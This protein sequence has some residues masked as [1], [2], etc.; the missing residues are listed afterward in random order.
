MINV[1]TVQNRVKQKHKSHLMYTVI[2]M[3]YTEPKKKLSQS[4]S[5]LLK[6]TT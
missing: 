6:G 1:V 2:Y 4:M 3:K 5:Q